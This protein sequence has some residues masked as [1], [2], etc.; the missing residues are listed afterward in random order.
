MAPVCHYYY[1]SRLM[2]GG[3]VVRKL[4]YKN[5][6]MLFSFIKNQRADAFLGT[7]NY[8]NIMTFL[9]L[10]L[11]S[12]SVLGIYN[13]IIIIIQFGVLRIKTLFPRTYNIV[14]YNILLYTCT[15]CKC[16]YDNAISC[17]VHFIFTHTRIRHRSQLIRF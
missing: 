14:Y 10:I 9:H 12:G 15:V 1:N 11:K 16:K 7:Y 5:Y 6:I 17:S 8:N 3:K 2:S 4:C 13:N